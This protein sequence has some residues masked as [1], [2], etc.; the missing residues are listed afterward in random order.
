M[1]T[2]LTLREAS[3]SPYA[4]GTAIGLLNVLAFATADRGLGVTTAFENAAALTARRF[5][6]N[7]LRTNSY[8]QARDETPKIDWESF[9]VL[10]VLGGSYLASR[11]SEAGTKPSPLER[12]R[13]RRA[14]P[15]A[16]RSAVAFLGGAIMMFGARMAKGCTTGHGI[17][18]TS[19][20]A[21]S[22]W[23]FT[24]LMFATAAALTRALHG[25][26]I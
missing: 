15:S 23:A 26:G 19:Q 7:A 21:L 11:A 2:Q 14:T 18:G 3:R 10:G 22:S 9:L 4:V 16:K 12:W 8:V 17:N 25:K 6:P 13:Q 5:A 1:N 24:P 20:L